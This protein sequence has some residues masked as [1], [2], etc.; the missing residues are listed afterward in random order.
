MSLRAANIVAM[1]YDIIGDIHGHADK[2]EALLKTMGYRH[3]LGAWRHP[4]STAIFVGDFIDRGPGQLRTVR[5][6]RK[7]TDAGTALAVMGNHEFNAIAWHSPDPENDGKHLRSRNEKH[8]SQHVRF[9]EEVEDNPD[10]HAELIDW[11]LTLPLW[12]ELPGLRVIHACWHLEYMTK[13]APRL[14]AGNRIDRALVTAASRRGSPEHDAIETLIKGM[15]IP[16]PRGHAFVDKDGHPRHA[17]R[18]RW[19]DTTAT[20]FRKAAIV[21]EADQESLPDTP[22]PK[23]ALL[24]YDGVAPVFFGHY[25]W[26]GTPAQ[27]IPRVA[28]VDFS[29]G[30]GGPLVAYRWNGEAELSSENFVAVSH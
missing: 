25:W 17:V 7:M 4:D 10:E 24:G 27:L 29:A 2:L 11:F 12:I 22:I 30:R 8:R 9:L 21:G 16:L 5:I 6:V 1:R 3:R 26:S 15:E 20:T 13:L 28:C 14:L 18:T 23:S 19:W